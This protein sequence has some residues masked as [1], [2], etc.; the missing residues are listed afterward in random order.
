MTI[1]QAASALVDDFVNSGSF[2]SNQVSAC[3]YGI[4]DTSRAGCIIVLQ[5]AQSSFETIGYGGVG[6]DNWGIMAEGYIKVTGDPTDAMTKVWQIHDAIVGAVRAGCLSGSN[7]PTHI[8]QVTNAT[9]GK[10]ILAGHEVVGVL[11]NISV[12][13]DP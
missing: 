1:L 2:L 9:T 6:L 7:Y 10:Y 11:V 12:R 5:P 8:T 13:E 4:I 3:D